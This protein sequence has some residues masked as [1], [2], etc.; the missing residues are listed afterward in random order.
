[1]SFESLESIKPG[2]TENYLFGYKQT[3]I[4][5]TRLNRPCADLVKIVYSCVCVLMPSAGIQK[6][7]PEPRQ[8][9]P[10]AQR[11]FQTMS[12]RMFAAGQALLAAF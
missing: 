2:V 9:E 11:V 12:C 3:D 6:L 10:F 8:L 5:T 1:M 4:A 7:W